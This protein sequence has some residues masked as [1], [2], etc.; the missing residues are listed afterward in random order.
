MAEIKTE[1]HKLDPGQTFTAGEDPV[2]VI[3]EAH[4]H[5][6]VIRYVVSDIGADARQLVED[7]LH[8]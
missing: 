4:S 8:G 1:L 3:T 6:D 5:A 2:F 7:A